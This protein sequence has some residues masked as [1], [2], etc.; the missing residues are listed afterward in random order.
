M[1]LIAFRIV[2]ARKLA[3]ALEKGHVRGK[4]IILVTEQGQ[5]G[6]SRALDDL[7]KCGYVPVE[8]IEFTPSEIDSIGVSR[9]VQQKL[10]KIHLDQPH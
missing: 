1:A 10:E 3:N 5:Q 6:A 8:I 7:R 9:S 4:R 2:I